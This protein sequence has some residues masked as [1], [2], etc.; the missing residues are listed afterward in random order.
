MPNWC[1][2]WMTVKGQEEDVQAF[3]NAVVDV[4]ERDNELH[5]IPASIF[6]KLLPKPENGS[7]EITNQEGE[8]IGFT[9]ADPERDGDEYINGWDWVHENWGT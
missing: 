5:N 1:T 3:A 6:D 7:K 4:E 2:N 9:F 8:V